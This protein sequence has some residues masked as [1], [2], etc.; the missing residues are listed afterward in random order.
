MRVNGETLS[1]IVIV[2]EQG[3]LFTFSRVFY[4]IITIILLCQENGFRHNYL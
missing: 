1:L 3:V 2:K 4:D